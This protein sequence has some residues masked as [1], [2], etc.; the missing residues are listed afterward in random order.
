MSHRRILEHINIRHADFSKLKTV[1]EKCREFLKEHASVDPSYEPLVFLNEVNESALGIY[2]DAYVV[3]IELS[4]YLA[5][6]EEILVGI[7]MILEEEDVK[8]PVQTLAIE[9]AVKL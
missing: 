7:Y 1:T 4:E 6:K 8:M 2:L 5:V 3:A 9:S